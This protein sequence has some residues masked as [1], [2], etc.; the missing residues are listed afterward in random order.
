[1]DRKAASEE[2]WWGLEN[3]VWGKERVVVVVVVVVV[4]FAAPGSSW[5]LSS[6]TRN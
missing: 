5:D 2:N 3:G 1:M 6:P 4:F